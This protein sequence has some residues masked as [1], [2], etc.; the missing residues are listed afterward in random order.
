[1]LAREEGHLE[2]FLIDKSNHDL[3]RKMPCSIPL[4]KKEP[5]PA[6]F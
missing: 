2:H 3:V 6:V 5:G 4:V 1:M